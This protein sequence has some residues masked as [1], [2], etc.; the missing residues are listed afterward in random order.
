MSNSFTFSDLCAGIGGFR[1]ALENQGLKCVFS[2]D[3]DKFCQDVYEHNFKERPHGDINDIAP[4]D[5]PDFDRA[6]E[7]SRICQN[8]AYQV[9]EKRDVVHQLLDLHSEGQILVSKSFKNDLET[10]F[11]KI[12]NA[13]NG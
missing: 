6:N 3:N 9:P 5:I 13:F 11:T 8:K 4:K 12:D 10:L 7:I 2:S 1:I